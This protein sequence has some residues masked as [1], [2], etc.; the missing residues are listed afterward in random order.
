MRNVLRWLEEAARLAPDSIAFDAPGRV[1]T[2]GQVWQAAQE[3]GSLLAEKTQAQQPVLILMDKSPDCL[4]A[5]LGAVCAG[6][7]YTPL[8][9]SMPRARVQ[10]IADTLRPAVILFEER[11]EELARGI[12]G[13]AR[14]CRYD[15]IPHRVDAVLLRERRAA[16]M[17]TDLL[18]V[19]FTSGSTGVPKGVS[20]THRSVIDLVEWA[21][22]ALRLPEGARFGSQ[23]PFYF[24]NSV[25]DIYCVMRMRGSLHLI[26]RMDFLFPA[27]LVQRL[28][29]ERIDTV[30]WVPSALTALAGADVLVPG[31][32]PALRRVFF[33]GEVMPCA[34]L[35][36]WRFALPDADYVNMYGPTEITDVCTWYRVDRAFADMD[37]L[38]IGFP[39]A[40][41]RV[42][43]IDGEICVSGTCLSPGYYNAPEKT[44]AAFVPNPLRP[45]IPELMYRT[46]DLGAYNDRGE[47]MFLGRRDSQIKHSGYRIELGEIE[48]ALSAAE[49]VALACCYYDGARIVAAYTGDADERTVKKH[50]R[51]ALP[52][53]ML[54]E[55]LLHRETLPRTGSGKVDRLTL[56]Q[57]VEHEHPLP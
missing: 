31:C 2:W 5:M 23:A 17:D 41:T 37:S 36:R 16:H 39:C 22:D 40:N 48:C 42:M 35:N 4:C 32:L 7:F 52:K 24:D 8:D 54:P 44:A 26:P 20:I 10:M 45:Q 43:L 46:G 34:T 33:C 19:L 30:F 18:Y 28:A 9:S 25:L 47:L 38:P 49:G 6:C 13:E 14:L 3:T 51:E 15:A 1:M 29:R 21:C 57:E 53:Y 55:L 12:A 27:R 11:N 56:R 50:L